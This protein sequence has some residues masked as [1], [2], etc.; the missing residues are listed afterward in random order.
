M[1]KWHKKILDKLMEKIGL[2]AYQVA[3][4]SFLKGILVT[5]IVYEFVLK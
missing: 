4:I 3:W 1:I 2:N 5:A